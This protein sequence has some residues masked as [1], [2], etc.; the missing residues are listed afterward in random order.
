[1]RATAFL[2]GLLA[3]ATCFGA[4]KM[5]DVVVYG[6]TSGGVAAAVQAARMGKTVVLIEPGR[7]LGGL[8]SGGLGATDI[9]NKAAIGGLSREFY[10]RIYQHYM[11]PSAWKQETLSEYKTRKRGR[12]IDKDTMWGFE[13]HVAER[14]FNDMVREAKVPVVFGQRLDLNIGVKKQGGRITAIKMESGRV[15]GG[16]MFIDATYEGDLMAKAGVSYAVGREGN[17]KYGE[18][19]NGVQVSQGIY[20]Q[21][22]ERV[23]PYVEPGDPSSGL[24]PGIQA[25]GPGD[26]GEGD[27]RVQAY[28]FR[29]CA[30]DVPENRVPWPKPDGY[31]AKRFE[32]LLRNIEA[33]DHRIVWIRTSMPNRKTDCN[34]RYAVSTD[35]IGMNYDYPD[36]DYAT[37]AR[38]LR[39]HEDYQKGLMW[40][41]ANHPRVTGEIRSYFQEWG[42][43]KDEF[44]DNGN[45]PHQLYV[46]EARRMVS[47]YVMTQHDC[48][49]DQT[50]SDPVGLGAYGMDSHHTQRYVDPEGHVRN[51]GDVQV[52]GFSPYPISYRSIVPKASECTNLVV[53]VCVSA[54]HIAYGSIRMEPVFMVLGQSAGTA[55]V[56]AIDEE[57]E[58]QAIDYPRLRNRLLA[59]GQVLVWTGPRR[60]TPAGIDPKSLP[61]VVVDDLAARKTGEWL[62]G[63]SIEPFVGF[64]Y[65][66]DGNEGKGQKSARFEA[67]LPE[68]GRYD[69]RLFY[70]PNPN[71][72]TNVPVTVEHANGTKSIRVNQ[73]QSL[74]EDSPSVSLGVFTFTADRPAVVTISNDGTDGYTIADAVHFLPYVRLETRN[75]NR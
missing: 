33:G 72:A 16:R 52:G 62:G 22:I 46:R 57:T 3:S 28:C 60:R 19:L 59:D 66:H 30:T 48:R 9:G 14:V 58:V 47:D 15:F 70:S 7:H 36:G 1:M 38:I 8:S 26:E 61:G 43:A 12:S 2:I 68:A 18:T 55:A 31:D 29:M 17:A 51:E 41:L 50:A 39:E 34:N 35:N 74:P 23:D 54:S 71:R 20:H 25:G 27:D 53:P 45:W 5:C 56:H 42:L 37:R 24:L 67:K 32:L 69:V 10:R 44:V 11:Q 75:S 6:G 73:R 49:G 64:G 13:P 65:A 40:T 63:R 4:E 21:F